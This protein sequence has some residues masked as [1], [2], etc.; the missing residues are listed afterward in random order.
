MCNRISLWIFAWVARIVATLWG[1]CGTWFVRLSLYAMIA[2]TQL[3][4]A[5][6]Y[7]TAALQAMAPG[8]DIVQVCVRTPNI[9]PG[10][11]VWAHNQQLRTTVSDENWDEFERV[12]QTAH[13]IYRYDSNAP[14][15]SAERLP[16]P[17]Q[18]MSCQ[19]L[20]SAKT[21]PLPKELPE[22]PIS[23]TLRE[24]LAAALMEVPFDS[25]RAELNKNASMLNGAERRYVGQVFGGGGQA[26]DRR[27]AQ[28]RI[29][30]VGEMLRDA[31]RWAMPKVSAGGP[32]D[33]Q[34]S[35]I[36][37]ETG[38]VI[39]G[40]G[41]GATIG[42]VPGGVFMADAVMNSDKLPAPTR[43][44]RKGEAIGEMA[45]GLFQM[46]AGTTMG[47]TGVGMSGTGGGAV[48]GVPMCVAGITLAANGATT[49]LH[50]TKSLWIAICYEQP[51]LADA[52]PL[53]AV[54]PKDPSSPS[55]PS[56][57]APSTATPTTTSAQPATPSTAPTTAPAKPAAKPVKPAAKPNAPSNGQTA[58]RR[59]TLCGP[60]VLSPN[61]TTWKR[62]TG[63]NHHAISAK[64][65]TELEKHPNLKGV[66]K[67]RDNRFVTQ[68][69]DESVHKGYQKWHIDLDNEIT[70]WIKDRAFLTPKDFDAYLRKR[71][72]APDLLNRFP[73]GL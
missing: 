13:V 4:C 21:V 49:F 40:I 24:A 71:Y 27:T 11:L 68:A 73:N 14:E 35:I 43:E 56:T 58:T 62:C 5:G 15:E 16:W 12:A 3:G 30:A 7:S 19:T 64:I 34:I 6:R 47:A 32:E 72:A 33:E 61:T 45:V 10:A 50:G 17:Y 9:G 66:Y 22:V 8:A 52:Q 23:P 2:L 37:T 60:T 29:E 48:V 70:K 42:T 46:G 63:Q 59:P 44:F 20:S 31:V 36:D 69:I 25:L 53:A 57:S 55:A 41:A 51:A 26:I 1:K 54:Q 39:G 28:E 67:Y 65:H 18:T 38:Q